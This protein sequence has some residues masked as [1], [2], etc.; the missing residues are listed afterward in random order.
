MCVA[1]FGSAVTH[2][3]NVSALI[4]NRGQGMLDRVRRCD[5]LG[6]VGGTL[7]GDRRPVVPRNHLTQPGCVLHARAIVRRFCGTA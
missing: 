5:R 7:D 6:A 4:G 2:I 3:L 1:A